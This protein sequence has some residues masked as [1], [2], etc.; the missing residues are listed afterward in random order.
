MELGSHSYSSYPLWLGIAS[1]LLLQ[2][3][4]SLGGGPLT[5][6]GRVGLMLSVGFKI[7][8]PVLES[9]KVSSQATFAFLTELSPFL[10][11]TVSMSSLVS[12]PPALAQP[13]DVHS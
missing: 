7:V 10:A 6:A 3:S 2:L 5:A 11:T 4:I 1:F 9:R 13:D 8:A 12:S